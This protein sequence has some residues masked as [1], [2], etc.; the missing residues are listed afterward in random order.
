MDQKFPSGV[1]NLTET[2]KSCFEFVHCL[3]FENNFYSIDGQ[4]SRQKSQYVEQQ[5]LL[6]NI[7]G[8]IH[9]RQS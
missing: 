2:E 9:G 4:A 3:N 6:G 7:M 8:Q 5:N 1:Q